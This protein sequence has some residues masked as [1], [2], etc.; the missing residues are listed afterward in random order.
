[1]ATAK[2]KKEIVQRRSR[3]RNEMNPNLRAQSDEIE[4]LSDNELA[5]TITS[6]YRIG[7][8]CKAVVDDPEKFGQNGLGLLCDVHGTSRRVMQ[9]N[10]RF[11]DFFPS[12]NDLERITGMVDEAT[13]FRLQWAHIDYL[14][15]IDNS[16]DLRWQFAEKALNELLTPKQL[17]QKIRKRLNRE[18]SGHGRPQAAPRTLTGQ[19]DQLHDML[20]TVL[21]RSEQ[22]WLGTPATY[23]MWRTLLELPDQGC[24][25]ELELQLQQIQAK[26]E[27]VQS[28]LSQNAANTARALTHVTGALRRT[29]ESRAAA[30]GTDAEAEA[31]APAPST[32]A[33][34]SRKRRVSV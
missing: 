19:L 6:H 4:R 20:N 14:L 11:V 15:T 17:L 5:E 2:E 26:L 23:S 8:I 9:R 3:A 28:T 32:P 7:Q 33:V 30:A 21:Q 22:I 16:P 25:A 13:G 18:S 27:E 29:S 10:V 12:E 1:M 31:E 34:R 24:T